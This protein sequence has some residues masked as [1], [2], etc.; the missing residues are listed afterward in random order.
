M[1]LYQITALTGTHCFITGKTTVLDAYAMSA[2]LLAIYSY[3]REWNWVQ[4][5]SN[6]I[7]STCVKLA[8]GGT[9]LH[10][11][12]KGSCRMWERQ[13]TTPVKVW[14]G[15][16]PWWTRFHKSPRLINLL[17]CGQINM[18]FND[19]TTVEK[20]PMHSCIFCK[21]PCQVRRYN[22]SIRNKGSSG[23]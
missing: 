7:S 17:T 12:F 6:P 9:A 3:M 22:R 21:T 5:G 20:T 15:P 4:T 14:P 18:I 8:T 16:E 19:P 23:D 1:S 13:F 11:W 2:S 10:G